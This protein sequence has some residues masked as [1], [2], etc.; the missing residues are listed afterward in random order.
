[1]TVEY[2]PAKKEIVWGHVKNHKINAFSNGRKVC[3]HFSQW[4]GD[5]H[6]QKNAKSAQ[7]NCEEKELS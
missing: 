2:L 1:M 4:Q 7:S 3:N 6:G 5:V